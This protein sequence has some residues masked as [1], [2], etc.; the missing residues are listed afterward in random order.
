MDKS[1]V[2]P[3]SIE[4]LRH[5]LTTHPLYQCEEKW[6]YDCWDFQQDVRYFGAWK[7][8]GFLLHGIYPSMLGN[9]IN[10]CKKIMITSNWWCSHWV[11]SSLCT[12]GSLYVVKTFAFFGNE[13]VCIFPRIQPSQTWLDG[14]M[15]RRLHTISCLLRRARRLKFNR[16]CHSSE[17]LWVWVHR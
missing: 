7:D 17:L 12:S 6:I 1:F 15:K 5:V 4:L 13:N 14:T 10:E 2:L 9:I 3:E 11:A 16:A 8:I